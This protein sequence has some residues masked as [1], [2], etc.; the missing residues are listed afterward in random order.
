MGHFNDL[1]KDI[2][3]LVLRQTFLTQRYDC[4]VSKGVHIWQMWSLSELELGEIELG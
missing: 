3:W 2:V 1:P 4:T